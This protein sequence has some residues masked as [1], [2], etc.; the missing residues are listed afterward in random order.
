MMQF[1]GLPMFYTTEM[2]G[3]DAGNSHLRYLC[4]VTVDQVFVPQFVSIVPINS[5][6][7]AYEDA[8]RLIAAIK[9]RAH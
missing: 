1:D 2:R 4:G 7:T 3:A 6:Q 8:I 9:A 5:M